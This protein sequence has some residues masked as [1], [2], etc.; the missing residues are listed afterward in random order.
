MA[1]TKVLAAGIGSTG[2][3]TLQNLVLTGNLTLNGTSSSGSASTAG[4]FVVTGIGSVGI[5]TNN[6]LFKADVDGDLRIRDGNKLRFGGTN[7]QTSNFYI[8]YNSTTN[9]L[10]FV[11]G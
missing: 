10:D 9:S 8:Q 6:P 2:T 11:A 1:F 4:N 5:G 3:V 7:T